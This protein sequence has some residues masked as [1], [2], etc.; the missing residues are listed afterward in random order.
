MVVT[1][2]LK[3]SVRNL[4]GQLIRRVRA[5][6]DEQQM[7]A[8][9]PAGVAVDNDGVM[10]VTE[11][12]SCRLLK[13][14][15][16]GKLLK[17]VGGRGKGPG[18]FH[19]PDGV[20]LASNKVY[21]CDRN[22][23]RVQIFDTDLNLISSFGTPGSGDGEF[24]YPCDLASDG[25]EF[26]YV[27]DCSNHRVQVFTVDGA[28]V[29]AFGELGNGPDK[30]DRPFGIHVHHEYIYMVERDKNHVSVLTLSGEFICSFNFRVGQPSLLR[31][32]VVDSD[33]YV[34]VCNQYN[35]SVD[36]Y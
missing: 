5:L 35:Q 12:D 20:A 6:A 8:F 15:S 32:I 33:G 25:V 1:E 10:F 3:L 22:N 21:V 36:V 27:A 19:Y 11:C 4:Q 24:N 7:V 26:V 13:V 31:G 28:F 18:Q 2:D 17:A 30:L 14:S 9:N 29:K 34:Y 23:Q 16:D